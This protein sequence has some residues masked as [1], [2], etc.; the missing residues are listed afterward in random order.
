MNDIR[1]NDSDRENK[2]LHDV[3]DIARKHKFENHPSIVYLKRG[4]VKKPVKKIP[5]KNLSK[6][7]IEKSR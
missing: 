3:L 2:F 4:Y 7:M 1:I 5:K 6:K